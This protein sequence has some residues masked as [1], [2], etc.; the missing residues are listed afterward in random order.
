MYLSNEDILWF[1]LGYVLLLVMFFTLEELMDQIFASRKSNPWIKLLP[2]EE[3]SVEEKEAKKPDSPILNPVIYNREDWEKNEKAL[4]EK[5]EKETIKDKLSQYK[6]RKSK[7]KAFEEINNSKLISADCRFCF[8]EDKM[9][10][11]CFDQI[12][13]KED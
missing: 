6:T 7:S 12:Y 4:E 9:C 2:E 1:L 11:D 13:L 3:S 10:K 8:R 5:L